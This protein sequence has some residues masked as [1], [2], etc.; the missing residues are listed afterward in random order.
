MTEP[1]RADAAARPSRIPPG[2]GLGCWAFGD[3]GTGPVD[4]E[5]SV[6]LIHSAWDL[7]VTHF[8]TAADYGNGRSEEV[9]G[10]AVAPFSARAFIASKA[11]ATEGE[12]TAAV[13][14]GILR[15]LGRSWLDL[16]YI[17]WPRTGLDLRPMMTALE[18]LRAQGK[19]RLIGVS[20]FGVRELENAS[21]AGR[22]DA[23]QLG[24]N[25]LWRYPENE[26]IP[27]C[28]ARGVPIVTY[29]SIA[30]GLLSDTPRG[31]DSFPAGDA[32]QKTLYYRPDVWPRV[33][34]SVEGMRAA[35][36]RCSTPLSTLAIRWVLGRPGV[37]S[38]LVGARTR[39]QIEQNV[40]AAAGRNPPEIDDEL[41]RRSTEAMSGIPDAGNMFLFYP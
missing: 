22:I 9:L 3:M 35:A 40:M 20:N 31:P 24:Y 13:V 6:A 37:V 19:I 12:K 29:S 7:G 4:A 41:T 1:P 10:K 39:R 14:E 18:S 28:R 30:Q 11:H 8:D 2:L 25:L 36:R 32:R 27:W 26:V 16:F 23:Y 34:E 15:R 21:E 5:A 33:R 17:H 38:S